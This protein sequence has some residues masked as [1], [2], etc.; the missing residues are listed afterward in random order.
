[1]NEVN[2]IGFFLAAQWN[3]IELWVMGRRPSA[4]LNFIPEELASLFLHFVIFA[5][6]NETK[7]ETSSRLISLF[8]FI[9]EV[10]GKKWKKNGLE[11][12]NP[13]QEN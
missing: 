3:Q 6:I 1:M 8:F 9:N 5:L 12:Y 10:K 2:G 7:K 4:Q 11:T 13:L